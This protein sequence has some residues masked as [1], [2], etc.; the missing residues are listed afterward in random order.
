MTSDRTTG[1]PDPD[2]PDFWLVTPWASG[3]TFCE[4]VRHFLT[5]YVWW[6]QS[7]TS[8]ARLLAYFKGYA[9]ALD[10]APRRELTDAAA[11]HWHDELVDAVA[12]CVHIFSERRQAEL[13]QAGRNARPLPPG[14]P[15]PV[16]RHRRQERA[17]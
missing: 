5:A 10:A 1:I 6:L 12:V 2:K 3:A 17:S 11:W 8:T 4:V 9:A 13:K 16:R 15:E 14:V 7:E